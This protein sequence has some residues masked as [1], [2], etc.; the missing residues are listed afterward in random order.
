MSAVRLGG[1]ICA[2]AG[3]AAD[4]ERDER[5]QH[6][7]AAH[8]PTRSTVDVLPSEWRN[9]S[10]TSP[11][12]GAKYIVREPLPKAWSAWRSVERTATVLKRPAGVRTVRLPSTVETPLTP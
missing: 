2:A 1:W 12:P 4:G 8:Q 7:R 3:G 11:L 5:A 9:V 6:Q 10:F